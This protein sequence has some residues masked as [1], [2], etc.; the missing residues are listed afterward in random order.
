MNI[1]YDAKRYFL[2]KTGLGNYS[3]D[4]IRILETYYP[5]NNYIKYTTKLGG[6][7]LNNQDSSKTVR[8][9]H[10]LINKLLPSLWRNN[11]IVN[12]LI[13]DKIDIYHGLSGEIPFNLHKTAIKSIT[14]IHDLIFIRF[15]ELYKPIDRYIYNQ[16]AKHAVLQSD[17]IIAISQQT[18]SDL[19]D[20]Y[21]LAEDKIE[22]IYQT[23]HT[24]FKT[25]KTQEQKDAI[26][27]KYNLPQHFILNVGTIE[28]RKN[29]FQIV[30]AIEKLDTSLVIVGRKTNY[31]K[32]IMRFVERTG[33]AKRVLFM[34]GLSMQELATIY[35]MADLFVYP[36]KFEGFGI[37]IIEALYSGLP[38][39]TSNSGVF[40]EAGGPSSCYVNPEDIDAI[41]FAIESILSSDSIRSQMINN[42]LEYVKRFDEDRIASQLI[43]CYKN[44]L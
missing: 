29:A 3:R 25:K 31:A 38:V 2:N 11:R 23:C 8:L 34:E 42:G 17:K 13:Q 14:T 35:V 7:D 41:Q 6:L 26:R 39:I 1:A 32:E 43:Q 16:K 30:K 21:N 5:E 28:P 9:P 24:S 12:D 19:I 18:K 20:T 40:P 37:P 10:G 4:L 33:M 36:S 27:T 44:V 22:V 15:P